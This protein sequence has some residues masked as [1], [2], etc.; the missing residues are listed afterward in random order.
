[1]VPSRVAVS[2]V[3]HDIVDTNTIVTDTHHDIH[4]VASDTLDG[5]TGTHT[6]VADVCNDVVITNSVV[7][8]GHQGV[9]DP[10]AIVS[11]LLYN[12]TNTHPDTTDIDRTSVKSQEGSKD[13]NRLVS[14]FRTFIYDRIGAYRWAMGVKPQSLK[15]GREAIMSLDAAINSVGIAEKNSSISPAK[16]AFSSVSVILTMIKVCSL[17]VHAG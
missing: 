2:D 7:S 12:T 13:K 3:H 17:R 8:D 16:A 9:G 10:H 1:M 5:V 14:I 15:G 4:V 6:I 11:E